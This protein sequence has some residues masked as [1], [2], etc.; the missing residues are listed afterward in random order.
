MRSRSI[1]EQEALVTSS[2]NPGGFS[3]EGALKLLRVCVRERVKFPMVYNHFSIRDPMIR[4]V[5]E[6]GIFYVLSW[7]D[8]AG[9]RI[10][11]CDVGKHDPGE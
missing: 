8:N 9:R 4:K 5:I 6:V 2:T 7:R 11:L 10:I 1:F 3:C